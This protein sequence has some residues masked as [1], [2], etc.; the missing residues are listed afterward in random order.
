MKLG[1]HTKSVIVLTVT[2]AFWA[3]AL[4]V[5]YN[6]TKPIIESTEKAEIDA[7]LRRIFPDADN[8]IEEHEHYTSL[9][10]GVPIGYATISRGYG[11][12]GEMKLLV[13]IG[14]DNRVVGVSVISNSE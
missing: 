7:T 9:K 4:A 10:E 12:G 13:G 1:V 14:L 11:Y 3:A 5:V 8:S 6:V 2:C